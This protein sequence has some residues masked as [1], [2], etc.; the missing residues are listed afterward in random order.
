MKQKNKNIFELKIILYNILKLLSFIIN[1]F[2]INSFFIGFTSLLYLL[3][4]DE[5]YISYFSFGSMGK[6]LFLIEII[7]LFW[8][9]PYFYISTIK[10]NSFSS[11]L[12]KKLSVIK[13][14]FKNGKFHMFIL[15]SLVAQVLITYLINQ[16]WL[17]GQTR[18]QLSIINNISKS[19]NYN[20]YEGLFFIIFITI[21]FSPL[22][23]EY[24]FR[25]LITKIL[26]KSFNNKTYANYIN[27]KEAL[28]EVI[29]YVF[30]SSLF[31]LMHI[32]TNLA[33]F[34]IYFSLGVLLYFIYKKFGYFGSVY[35]HFINNLLGLIPIIIVLCR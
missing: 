1:V 25:H 27:K 11:Y 10:K 15:F 14:N 28:S 13:S 34:S 16:L 3:I 12:L 9:I 5:L 20:F 7:F 29:L 4:K 2:V 23:E 19:I 6:I 26:T 18:N 21:I 33:E 35:L 30:S 24:I 31:S 32:P 22:I 17:K 8:I